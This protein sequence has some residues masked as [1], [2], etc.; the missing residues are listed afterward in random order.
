MIEI[1]LKNETYI[2]PFC[3][4]RQSYKGSCDEN[5]IG[6]Y[7][8]RSTRTMKQI[9]KDLKV[10]FLECTNTE[11]QEISII[12]FNN[13]KQIDIIPEFTHKHFPDYIPEQIKND[14]VE[15]VAI[16][17]YS[18]K[19]AST[20]FRRCLQGMIRDFWNIKDKRL[21]EEIK[22]LEEK[23]S[24][25]Q[26]KAIDAVRKI[27]NIGAHMEYDVNIVIDVTPT[28]TVQ[29]QKLIEFLIEKWYIERQE[30]EDLTNSIVLIAEEKEKQ[31]QKTSLNS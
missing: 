18:P 17:K 29:L 13:K 24:P 21:I 15:G 25:S 8:H 9:Q 31:K 14:Y 26:W 28:E 27:G 5:D 7:D 23:V 19:A 3:S 11:C 6:Y 20:M 30:A 4:C 10:F 2:C 16:L 22:R 12:A 1:N